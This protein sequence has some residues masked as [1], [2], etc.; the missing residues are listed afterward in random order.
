MTWWCLLIRLTKILPPLLSGGCGKL[1]SVRGCDASWLLLLVLAGDVVV[2]YILH[3]I[4][5]G[6]VFEGVAFWVCRLLLLV[7]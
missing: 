1:D 2:D 4:H 5:C 3:D 7:V 6:Q